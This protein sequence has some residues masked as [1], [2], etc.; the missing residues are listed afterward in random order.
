MSAPVAVCTTLPSRNAACGGRKTS[1]IVPKNNCDL[2]NQRS[3]RD[4]LTPQAIKRF[5]RSVRHNKLLATTQLLAHGWLMLLFFHLCS[6]SDRL[7]L[8]TQQYA[9]PTE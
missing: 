1:E 8:G 5:P 7:N 6:C 3:V 2:I 9:A 4:T